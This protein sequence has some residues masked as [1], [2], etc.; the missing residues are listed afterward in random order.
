MWKI[1]RIGGNYLMNHWIKNSI[2]LANQSNYLDLL[3]NI[4]PMSVNLKRELSDSTA[5]E[6]EQHFNEKNDISL[7]SILLKQDLFP[8]KD[9]YVAFLKRDNDAVHRNPSTVKRIVNI[10]YDMGLDEVL[11]NITLPKETNRQM[12]PLFKNWIDKGELGY[13]ITTSHLEILESEENIILNSSDGNMMDFAKTHLGYQHNKGLDFIAKINQKYVVG[14]AKFLTDFGGHQNAQF[15]DAISTLTADFNTEKEI[16][17]IAILDGVVYLEN[18]GKMYNDI[19]TTYKDENIISAVLLK[20][21]LQS[22]DSVSSV[23]SY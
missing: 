1:E 19:T 6:I 21:F 15:N 13:K 18:K 12:G 14:E 4:Y 20:D 9:S 11:H 17:T 23:Y 5:K 16:I 7:L 2:K 8:I 10:L 22:I 3:Y